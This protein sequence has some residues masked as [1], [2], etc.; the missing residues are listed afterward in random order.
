[1][2]RSEQ[3]NLIACGTEAHGPLAQAASETFVYAQAPPDRQ[4]AP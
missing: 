4:A 1:M 3:L 2:R